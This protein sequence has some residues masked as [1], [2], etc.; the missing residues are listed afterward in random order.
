MM[1]P[2]YRGHY[3]LMLALLGLVLVVLGPVINSLTGT[4]TYGPLFV[5][6]GLIGVLLALHALATKAPGGDDA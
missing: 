3:T 4:Q 2:D 6:A 5:L 1:K